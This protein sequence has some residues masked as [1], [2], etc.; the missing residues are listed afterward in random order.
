MSPQEQLRVVRSWF[1][2]RL[3]VVAVQV[4]LLA[5]VLLGLVHLLALVVSSVSRLA[6]VPILLFCLAVPVGVACAITLQ[7][8]TFSLPRQTGKARLGQRLFFV[9][10]FMD[11]LHPLTWWRK[12]GRVELDQVG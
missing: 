3:Y 12:D 10:F 7:V 2:Y 9:A 5:L 8:R 11:V 1:S 4:V 6:I